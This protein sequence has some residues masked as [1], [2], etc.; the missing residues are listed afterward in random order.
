MILDVAFFS[1][2]DSLGLVFVEEQMSKQWN[3]TAAHAISKSHKQVIITRPVA[4]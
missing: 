1:S 4:W 2:L 3:C